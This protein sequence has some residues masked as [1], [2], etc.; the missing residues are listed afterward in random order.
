MM[1]EK[2]LFYDSL[3]IKVNFL[4]QESIVIQKP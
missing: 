3:L 4:P 1:I 2:Y